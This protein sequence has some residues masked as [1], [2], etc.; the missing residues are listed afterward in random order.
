MDSLTFEVSLPYRELGQNSR[1]YF[2]KKARLTKEY[3]N[4][5]CFWATQALEKVGSERPNERVKVTLEYGIK[6]G[7]A[8]GRYQPRDEANAI[9]AWKAGYDGLV[10]A[11]IAISDAA[12]HMHNGG[13]TI[14]S[15]AGPWVRVTVE[16]CE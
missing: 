1:V 5:V 15:K 3:R 6:G 11:G 2:R 13:A 12:K 8:I 16:P 9:D 7:R 10:D 14:N 4:E